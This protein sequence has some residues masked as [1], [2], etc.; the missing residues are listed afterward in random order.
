MSGRANLFKLLSG[1]F[2]A[3]MCTMYPQQIGGL[4]TKALG[5]FMNIFVKIISGPFLKAIGA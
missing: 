3:A 2:I 5:L 4:V 1:F